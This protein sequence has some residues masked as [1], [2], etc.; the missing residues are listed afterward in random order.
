MSPSATPTFMIMK[1]FPPFFGGK[2]FVITRRADA[3]AP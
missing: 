3:L 1:G 2:G